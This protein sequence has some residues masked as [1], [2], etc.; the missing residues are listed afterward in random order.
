MTCRELVEF[1]A[2]YLDGTLPR[3]ERATFEEHLRECPDCVNYLATYCAT[4][5]LARASGNAGD[6]ALP[7]MP[8]DLVHAVRAVIVRPQP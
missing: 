6:I 8:E 7:E 3:A 5:R 2:D 1:L 4:I